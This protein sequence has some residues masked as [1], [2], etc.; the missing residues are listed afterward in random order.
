MS[1]WRHIKKQGK[2]WKGSK[3]NRKKSD[4]RKRITYIYIICIC[5]RSRFSQQLGDNVIIIILGL[6]GLF[7]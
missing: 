7:N 5:L 2:Y 3:G 1:G 6:E 4:L